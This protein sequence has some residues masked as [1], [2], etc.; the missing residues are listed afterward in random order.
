MADAA[1]FQ[2]KEIG[3]HEY[4]EI[5]LKR[6]Y[7]FIA[8]FIIASAIG[9]F[10]ILRQ[11]FVYSSRAT[12]L[13]GPSTIQVRTLAGGM[14]MQ[15]YEAQN[16]IE[17]MKSD[18][19]I[20][21]TVALINGRKESGL[22][23]SPPEVKGALGFDIN[24]DKAGYMTNVI[25][26]AATSTNP[27]KALAIVKNLMQAYI[28]ESEEYRRATIKQTYDLI[29][30]Q[31]GEKRKELE[32]AEKRLTK[33]VIDHDVIARGIEVGPK[34]EK[35]KNIAQLKSA[36]PMINEKYLSLKAQR[37]EKES[38]LDE[39]KKHR[40]KDEITTLGV[41][42]KKEEKLV[43]LTLR[44]AL[45]AKEQELSKRLLTESELHPDVIQ[46]KG[47][48]E[49]ARKRISQEVDKAIDSLERDVD[50][51]KRE[52]EKLYTLI[53]EGLSDTMVE[54]ATL[55]RDVAIKKEV[56]DNFVTQLQQL[57]IS[58]KLQQAQPLK[59][60][61][62]PVLPRSP[63]NP[64]GAKV[65][66]AIIVA[67]ILGVGAVVLVESMDISITN[68]EDIEDILGA[69]ALAAI[70][71]W[72]KKTGEVHLGM[73]SILNPKSILSEAFRTLRTNIKFVG[74]DKNIKSIVI[75]SAG[76]EE[77]KS[78][79]ASN[80]AAVMAMAGD[81]VV[82]I[83]ADLRRPSIHNHFNLDNASGLSDMLISDDAIKNIP[84]Q[85]TKLERLK[86][87][88]SGP[89]PPNPSEL[90]TTGKVDKI[91]ERLKAEYDTI[92]MD[93]SPILTVTDSLILASK[94]D[95]A[96]LVFL[97]NKTAKRAGQRIR[98]L[99]KNAGVNTL[100]AVLNKVQLKSGGYGGYYY[101]SYKYY[102][103]DK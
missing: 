49:E 44:D 93:S 71:A 1:P 91:L 74:V 82:L 34:E 103:A 97:A 25:T 84:A 76:P 64:K 31:L 33:F 35:G 24:K 11:S 43:D 83:D 39:I 7:I 54:Y 94:T 62:A 59:I 23:V 61:E 38:F 28:E 8:V 15:R 63:T 86:V 57:N 92:I 73:I 95:G 18:A 12:I 67:M 14:I 72:K 51:L 42:S 16:E 3:I 6:R 9:A 87:I 27:E 70:P 81:R 75:T 66:Q 102:G 77:G 19:V 53:K 98:Q 2:E 10:H 79:I 56:H 26:I 55:Q 46:A 48:V 40:A 65:M 20:K 50:S 90:L 41:I 80:L 21:R 32:D 68:V 99:L 47:E 52:E 30:G 4:I 69:T 22:Q 5:F 60:L 100:G 13:I 37:I 88:T 58:E 96:V 89:I 101:Y 17:L 78:T 36:E 45:Y 29:A 85:D